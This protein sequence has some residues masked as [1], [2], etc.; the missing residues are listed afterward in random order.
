MKINQE[1]ALERDFFQRDT[2]TVAR[3]LLGKKLVRKMPH[4]LTSG[5]IIETEA[6][7]GTSD[8]A[9]HAFGGVTPRSMIMFGRPGVAYIYLCY[10]VYWLL[11][12]VT[13]KENTPGAVLIRGLKPLEGK[14]IMQKRRKISGSRNLV[15]GPGKLTIAMGID[16]TQNG[17]DMTMPDNGLYISGENTEINEFEI[18]ST[19][20]IGIKE[21]KD[22]MLRFIAVGL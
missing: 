22:R 9:S 13:E 10:G 19:S 7:Y 18:E 3:N 8:P 12:V 4:G 15:D 6:Y 14:E 17:S 20:R 21:G 11:N 5:I 1:N 2:A 16:G